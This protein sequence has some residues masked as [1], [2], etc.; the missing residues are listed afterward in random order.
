[1]HWSIQFAQAKGTEFNPRFLKSS[2]FGVRKIYIFAK[3]LN[4]GGIAHMNGLGG[5]KWHLHGLCGT[6]PVI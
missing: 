2:L 1:M 6:C 3:I 5:E 4:E